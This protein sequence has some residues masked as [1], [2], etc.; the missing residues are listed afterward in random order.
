MT[1]QAMIGDDPLMCVWWATETECA[2]AIA[3]L[4]REDA[5]SGASATAAFARLDALVEG[6]NEVQ[7]AVTLRAIAR[8]LLRVH[9]L[10][11]ADALQLAA[12]LVVAEQVP[13][14]LEIVTLDAR[15]AGV[16]RREGFTALP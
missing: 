12:A 14:S 5:L 8:R 3:R 6:W 16:A 9:D 2:S 11:A 13:S 1:V 15:L 4:E 10:R 7:P